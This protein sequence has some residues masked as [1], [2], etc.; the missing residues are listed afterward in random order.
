MLA[1][2]HN[3]ALRVDHFVV[4]YKYTT[5]GHES[6]T[7]NC[8]FWGTLINDNVVVEKRASR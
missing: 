1:Q 3:S 4:T 5:F 6:D 7:E 2:G 8:E